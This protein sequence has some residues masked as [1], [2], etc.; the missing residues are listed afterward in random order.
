MSRLRNLKR[1]C[2]EF[3]GCHSVAN[4]DHDYHVNDGIIFGSCNGAE[5]MVTAAK[6]P[7][8]VFPALRDF[9]LEDMSNIEEW[10]GLGV[11]S[12]SSDTTMFFPLL[13][14]LFIRNC[15]ELTII[16]SH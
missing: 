5:T 10:C 15:L 1:I 6:A 3:Y 9:Y 4:H 13:E 8:V 16:P 2:P 14:C 11:S 12:S 7:T